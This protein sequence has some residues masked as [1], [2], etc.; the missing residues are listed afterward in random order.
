MLYYFAMKEI[1]GNTRL[2]ELDPFMFLD[3]ETLGKHALAT[4]P[5]I[6]ISSAKQ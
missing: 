2:N 1:T 4:L 3:F 5:S 6:L